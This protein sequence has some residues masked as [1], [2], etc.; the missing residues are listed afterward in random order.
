MLNDP[1]TFP[2]LINVI[3]CTIQLTAVESGSLPVRCVCGALE[4]PCDSAPGRKLRG[5]VG[6]GQ[7]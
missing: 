6:R 2:H 4:V 3:K 5:D 7:N 1:H